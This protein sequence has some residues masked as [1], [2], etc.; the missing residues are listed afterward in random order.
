MGIPVRYDAALAVLSDS[1]GI[2]PW[3]K[4]VVG[5]TFHLLT[6]RQK[7]A[8]L[9]HEVGHCKLCHTEKIIAHTIA[10][11]RLVFALLAASIK[12]ARRFKKETPQALAFFQYEIE[13]MAPGT[14]AF[15]QRLEFEAD[16]YAAGCG[17]GAELAQVFRCAGD[18]GGGFHPDVESRVRHVLGESHG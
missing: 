3:K 11:P 9:L 8:V 7:G 1:R 2:G 6:E 13:R 14:A 15:R 18:A 10:R 5:P 17:Y 4:I 12:A 16:A